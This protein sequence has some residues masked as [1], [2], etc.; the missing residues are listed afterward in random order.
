MSKIYRALGLM[1]GTSMDGI[2]LA[3]IESDGKNIINSSHFSYQAYEKEFKQKLQ[4]LINN[5][6][7]SHKSVAIEK[8][9]TLLHAKFVNAFIK[10]NNIDKDSI[11]LI[12]FHG[13]TILHQ[14]EQNLTWQIGDAKLLE[15]ETGIKVISQLRVKDI[16]LGGQGAPLVPIY[17][18]HL[19]NNQQS[20]KAVLNIGGVSNITYI[21]CDNE[22]EIEAFDICFGNA[23]LDDLVKKTIH[24]D[25]DYNGELAKQGTI[26]ITIAN[27]VLKT[28]FI[29]QKP[30]K[31]L[32]RN[33]FNLVLKPL[34]KL[35]LKDALA[36][37]CYI[38]AESI[39]INMSFLSNKP[40]EIF[41]CGGG[42]K[43]IALID[44]MKTQM[45]DI[46]I[47]SVEEIGLDGDAIEAQ[48]FAF[49]GIRNELGLSIGL[50][51]TTGANLV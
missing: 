42:R 32:D 13:H 31:S 49:I 35:A 7:S 37:L 15:N 2:D 28:P 27:Q 25:F 19:F 4:D 45:S 6:V 12:S 9:L 41:I 17:H 20:P 29:N 44:A 23:P 21:G 5:P 22:S 18:F 11:D 24:K 46:I 43:N 26:N 10:E 47:R 14:P 3:I 38:H 8:E 16:N 1:S 51:K 34:T 50:P 33:D 48:A 40:R 39:R 36:T 30:P